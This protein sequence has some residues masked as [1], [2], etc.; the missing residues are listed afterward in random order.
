MTYLSAWMSGDFYFQY[1]YWIPY[2]LPTSN[3][4]DFFSFLSFHILLLFFFLCFSLVLMTWVL[5]GTSTVVLPLYP[6]LM[7]SGSSPFSLL[8]SFF[9]YTISVSLLISLYCTLKPL[10]HFE[11]VTHCPAGMN[12]LGVHVHISP[13]SAGQC[14]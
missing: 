8:T 12:L 4:S 10:L 11:H 6:S 7:R 5:T 3:F 13:L 14:S 2:E 1:F 9:P